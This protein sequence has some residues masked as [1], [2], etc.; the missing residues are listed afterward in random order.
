M[1]HKIAGFGGSGSKI[2]LVSGTDMRKLKPACGSKVSSQVRT[3]AW[4][5]EDLVSADQITCAKCRA[6]YDALVAATPETIASA[7]PV[8]SEP[9]TDSDIPFAEGID[10]DDS[11]TML[12]DVMSTDDGY[13]PVQF[14]SL[15]ADSSTPDNMPSDLQHTPDSAVLDDAQVLSSVKAEKTAKMPV[16]SKKQRRK[17][18]QAA[19]RAQYAAHKRPVKPVIQ[20]AEV[21][22]QLGI[23]KVA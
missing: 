9:V 10:D 21:L 13:T 12:A 11:P 3:G 4:N 1:A 16:I 2:H 8:D 14:M 23:G 20:I 22:R 5:Y 15:F 7:A 6:K 17:E 18:K 19:I